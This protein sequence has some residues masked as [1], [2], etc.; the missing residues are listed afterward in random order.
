MNRKEFVELCTSE[1]T[2]LIY[3]KLLEIQN[4]ISEK[5]SDLSKMIGH[6]KLFK[7]A[8][9]DSE[10]EFNKQKDSYGIAEFSFALAGLYLLLNAFIDGLIE[11]AEKTTQLPNSLAV[12]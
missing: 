3:E 4:K 5:P 11:N 1:Q 6:F 8:I 2:V 9:I 7:Q 10:E 12:I